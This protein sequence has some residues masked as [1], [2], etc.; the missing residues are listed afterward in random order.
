MTAQLISHENDKAKYTTEVA[1]DVFYKAT[2]AVYKKNKG[3]FQ[4]PG[5]RKGRAPR[6]VIEMNYGEGVFYDDALNSILPD[7]IET[8]TKALGLEP[9]GRPDV[10]V[11]TFE[12]GQPIVFEIETETQPHPELGDYTSIE[13]EKREAVVEASAIDEAIEQER[14]KNGIMKQIEDRAAESGDEV[15]IDYSGTVDGVKFDGGTAEKQK[16][17]LGSN[18]FIP[19][20]EDQVIGHSIGEAF[21][22]DVTF[23]EDY[24]S[25]TL[26][27]KAAVFHIVLH[28]ISVKELPDLDDEFAQDVS[29]FDTLEA[30]RE[31]VK[32]KL[33]ERLEKQNRVAQENEAI[34][35]L[36]EISDV[37][38]PSVMIDEQVENEIRDMASQVQQMGISLD[39]YLKYTGE[40]MD[41]LREQYRPVA[42]KRVSGDLVLGSLI[43][44]E[45]IEVSDEE[46][47]AELARLA[48][49]Y[50]AKDAEDF[51]KRVREMGNDTMVAEDLRKKKA[52]D[53]LMEVVQYVDAKPVEEK[54]EGADAE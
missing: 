4:I 7:A 17:V 36:I 6:K 28:G 22:I 39:Q 10:D 15:T 32:A 44:K 25:E 47:D 43:I 30:Y 38:V 16:L 34:E 42:E 2:E 53:R 31:D 40:N 48:A 21:D 24:G 12:V 41:K 18:S 27:G 46:L 50:G 26:A 13:I 29:E 51:A 3:R 54:T 20:F 49:V 45:G 33:T 11:K 14:Q 19:G 35:K 37:H 9:I 52:I 23:P 8:A 5:F 1:W